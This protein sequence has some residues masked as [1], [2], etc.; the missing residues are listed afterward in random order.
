MTIQRDDPTTPDVPPE[1]L[2]AVENNLTDITIQLERVDRE[3]VQIDYLLEQTTQKL[4][5]YESLQAKY[6]FSESLITQLDASID[7][8]RPLANATVL[9]MV[10]P[11]ETAQKHYP[12]WRAWGLRIS[13]WT[14]VAA[15]M[16]TG[17]LV[18]MLRPARPRNEP[19]VLSR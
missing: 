8:L 14:A 7:K 11:A 18:A 5:E 13:L 1:A 3:M 2:D 15:L 6:R 10:S 4:R 12:T 16:G 17:A 19:E 9:A